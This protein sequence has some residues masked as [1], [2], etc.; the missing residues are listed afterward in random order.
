MSRLTNALAGVSALAFISLPGV[1]WA[2]DM[3]VHAVIGG[4]YANTE[5]FGV[6]ADAVAFGGN[7][8][9]SGMSGIGAEGVVGYANVS[10]GGGSADAWTVGGALFYRTM[11]YAIGGGVEHQSVDFGGFSVNG[12]NYGGAIEGYLSEMVTLSA[13]GGGFSGSGASG[14]FIG[15]G[16][17]LY[18][19]P[20]L[21][22]GVGIGHADAGAGAGTTSYGGGLEFIPFSTFQ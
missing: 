2:Q 8:I 20:N 7:V 9:F 6:N 22:L 19:I 4:V 1:S 11:D 10:A 5:V 13:N 16:A 14:W 18:P 21:A 3:P 12:T 17:T 15:G